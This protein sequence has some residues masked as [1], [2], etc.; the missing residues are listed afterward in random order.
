M[1]SLFCFRSFVLLT[2]LNLF[3]LFFLAQ[4]VDVDLALAGIDRLLRSQELTFAFV[5]VA[6]SFLIVYLVAGWLKAFLT[7]AG[8]LSFGAN[9][10]EKRRKS[11]EGI[12]SV[13][14]FFLQTFSAWD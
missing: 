12:R 6:P 5:G 14:F 8:G 10:R 7:G 2:K 9:R 13:S 1:F 3:F 11:W 4:K